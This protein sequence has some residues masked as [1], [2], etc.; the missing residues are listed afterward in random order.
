[1]LNDLLLLAILLV[2]VSHVILTHFST[3]KEPEWHDSKS[4]DS[5]HNGNV[6]NILKKK[7]VWHDDARWYDEEQKQ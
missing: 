1:M 5:A 6:D 7:P 4:T 3:K 2:L